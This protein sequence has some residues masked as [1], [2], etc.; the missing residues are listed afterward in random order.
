MGTTTDLISSIKT[1]MIT[2][3]G[4]DFSELSNVTEIEKNS[5]KGS[6]KRYGVLANQADEVPGTT[7]HLTID[8]EFEI[9]LTNGFY[10]NVKASDLD[11]RTKTLELQD[12]IKE[13]YR[14]L[15]SSKAGR[16]DLVIHTL[17]LSV[18]EPVFLEENHVVAITATFT[19]KYRYLL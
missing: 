5:F 12:L 15:K 6:D 14:D 19:L 18:Q 2:V 1:R 16:P 10:S 13:V 9:T 4:P 7:C 17:E 11:K 3:L 8:Q